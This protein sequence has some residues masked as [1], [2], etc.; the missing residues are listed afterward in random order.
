MEKTES[1]KPP[2]VA[3]MGHIDHGKS[4]LLSY[5]RKSMKPL[6]EIGG[7]TQSISSYEI[8]HKNE[9]GQDEKITFID[10]PGH[11]AFRSIRKRGANIA[12]IAILVVSAEDGVKPQTLEALKFI[13]E[14]ST[15]F[16][17]AI[18]KI[19]KPDANI[20]KTKTSLAENEI[21]I[22]GYGGTIPV[23]YVSA[24]TGEGVKSLL[25]MILLI[26]DM[27]G[28]F[29]QK[30]KEA[31]GFILES[32]KDSKNGITATCIIKNG[33]LQV[34]DFLITGDS[35]AKIKMIENCD[36]KKIP[37]ATFSSPVK[38][39]GFDNLPKAGEEFKV[40]KDKES[41]EKMKG[42][43]TKD[44]DQIDLNSKHLFPI[45]VKA[46]TVGRLEAVLYEISK[47]NNEEISTKIIK[48]SVGNITEADVKLASGKENTLI[49]GFGIKIDNLA[50]NLAQRTGVSIKI[51][52]I[53]YKISEWLQEELK[54]KIPKDE[55]TFEIKGTAKVLKTFS[56]VK[57]RQV[58]GCKL[59]QGVIKTGSNIK[60]FR[61]EEE[62]A[63]GKVKKLQ[64]QKTETDKID[65][66][67]DFGSMVE[68]KIEIV[69][70]DKIIAY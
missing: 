16:I 3:I 12:D 32:N 11:E 24:K 33:S 26:S 34:G 10:T 45:I 30:S 51:F 7:I 53:I 36:G 49:L 50:S 65:T 40:F 2:V 41:A 48:S 1:K 22:E 13:K 8:I 23:V 29:G 25:D 17:V 57:D 6:N 31:S 28:S 61:R 4:T 60:V 58:I 14:S 69:S 46:D 59:E 35:T 43:I 44:E 27:E 38:I 63:T 68:C 42:Q 56:K 54:N 37:N 18:T 70:G 64:I 67:R 9:Q 20:E 39:F 47:L 15:P 52:D 55:N 62:I 21:Y 5:I 19:D 66:E